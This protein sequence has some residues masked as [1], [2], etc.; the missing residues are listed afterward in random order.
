MTPRM[1]HALRLRQI[2]QMQRE[3]MLVGIIASTSA[4]YSF[5]R[6]EKPLSPSMFM[7][8]PCIEEDEP[9][10]GEDVMAAFAPFVNRPHVGISA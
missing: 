10:T 6:P 1:L 2:E 4:N 7:L 3:E 9:L 5:C 8:H